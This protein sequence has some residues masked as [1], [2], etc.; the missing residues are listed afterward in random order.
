[1]DD[2][3]RRKNKKKAEKAAREAADRRAHE[4]HTWFV[5]VGSTAVQCGVTWHLQVCPIA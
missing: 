2:L 3:L 5:R 4:G 1:M